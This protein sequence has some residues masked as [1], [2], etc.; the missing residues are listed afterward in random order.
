MWQNS[1]R[2][3][4]VKPVGGMMANKFV[5]LTELPPPQAPHRHPDG[6]RHL[7]PDC[8]QKPDPKIV[9]QGAKVDIFGDYYDEKVAKT[10]ATVIIPDHIDRECF[11][12]K[13]C[14]LVFY[15]N[16][17]LEKLRGRAYYC[18]EAKDMTIYPNIWP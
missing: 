18:L 10:V 14:T 8:S 7:D 12:I 11:I 6:R 5:P 9:Y 2:L 17:L 13:P 16:I 4:N 15:S 3:I 1:S